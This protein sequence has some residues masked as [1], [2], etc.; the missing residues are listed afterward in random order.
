MDPSLVCEADDS[1]HLQCHDRTMSGLPRFECANR[2]EVVAVAAQLLAEWDERLG[3]E[4]GNLW[5]LH[6]LLHILPVVQR[7][8]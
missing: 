8:C 6:T 4:E 3:Q 7:Y 1:G 2:R 5:L